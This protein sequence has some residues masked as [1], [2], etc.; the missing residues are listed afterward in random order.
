MIQVVQYNDEYRISF[1]YDYEIKEL[2]KEVPGRKWNK[3]GKYWSIPLNHLGMFVNRFK[4]TEFEDSIVIKSNENININDT[5]DE[6]T[7]IPDID[8]SGVTEYVKDGFS[9]YKHQKDFLKFAIDRQNKGNFSGFLCA[10]QMGAGKTIEAINLALYNKETYGIKHCL[11]ICCINMSKYN[12]Q[13]EIEYQTNGQYEGYILGSRKKKSGKINPKGS[14][15]QKLEDLISG[16]KYNDESEGELPFFLILNVEAI[17]MTENRVYRIADQI[18]NL[19]NNNK[20]EMC[21][22]DEVHKNVSPKSQQGKQLLRIK[23]KTGS[24]CMWIPMTGTPIVNQPTDLFVP[25][26]LVEAHSVDSFYSWTQYFCIFG[27]YGDHEIVGYKNMK[28]LKNMLQP[29][30]IRRLKEDI[31]DLPEKIEWIEYVENTPYQNKLMREVQLDMMSHKE[32][33]ISSLNPLAKMLRL[34]QVNGSPE[35]VDFECVTDSTYL[36][37]NAKLSRLIELVGEI[38]SRGEKVV[39]FSNWVEPLRTVYKYLKPEYN[40]IC[41]FTGTMSEKDRQLHKN[42]FINNPEYK[43][44]IGTIGALGTTHTL[45]VA[46]NVIFYDEP[47]T[48]SDRQQAVDRCHRISA[49]STVN[50]YTL[51]SKDTIDER[52]HNILYRKD[53][54]SK[55]I[56][57]GKLDI[58]NNPELF[59]K[60][61]GSD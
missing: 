6:T 22:I 36:K 44:L 20:I 4:G 9:L 38:L 12:W 24:N 55:F 42:T 3:D 26:R 1:P 59:D 7:V 25:L 10:D 14:S 49:T 52:V 16:F 27:G 2:V 58:Y 46:N 19:I 33:I 54:T 5:I 43:I 39:I 18:I 13:Q 61:L 8:I 21:V 57:D 53:I 31:L 32:D 17:R 56:V 34:R 30:M 50:V 48:A 47:W 28:Y 41:C 45:T 35:L 11:I 15:K 51:L 60:L 37:K 23:K 29:N 40:K